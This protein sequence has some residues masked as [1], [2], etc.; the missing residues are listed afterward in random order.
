MYFLLRECPWNISFNKV[1]GTLPAWLMVPRNSYV[2]WDISVGPD[3]KKVFLLVLQISCPAMEPL[4]GLPVNIV[5]LIWL[6]D[7]DRE[8]R[9][10]P[11]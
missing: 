1:V 7:K 11:G 6:V 2:G 9:S 4:V 5:A 10:S 3:S 8:G